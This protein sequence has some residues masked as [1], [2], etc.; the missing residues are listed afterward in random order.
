MGQGLRKAFAAARRTNLTRGQRQVYEALSDVFER[1]ETIAIR[2]GIATSSPRET[3]STFCR[4]LV[5]IG[6]AEKG[7]T[8]MSPM[9]RRAE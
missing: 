7:G 3:A 1:P 8:P 2:A 5:N 4:Q 9:W 6:L